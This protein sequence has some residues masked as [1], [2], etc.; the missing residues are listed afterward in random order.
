MFAPLSAVPAQVVPR[1][2]G[3]LPAVRKPALECSR[4]GFEREHRPRPSDPVRISQV[5]HGVS[6][7]PGL[8]TPSVAAATSMVACT[9][10]STIGLHRVP[11]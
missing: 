5:R 8:K 10:G 3:E 4:S 9:A 11:L 1:V 2:W 6:L 7:L